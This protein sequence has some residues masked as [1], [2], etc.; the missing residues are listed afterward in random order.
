MNSPGSH[1]Q[2]K[3]KK[4]H[5]KQDNYILKNDKLFSGKSMEHLL[6]DSIPND[7]PRDISSNKTTLAPSILPQQVV[8]AATQ[9]HGP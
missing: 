6:L 3:K 1:L 9:T 2:E 7:G 4:K 8:T 5:Q